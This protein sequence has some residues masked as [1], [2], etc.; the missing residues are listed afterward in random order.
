[1]RMHHTPYTSLTTNQ[2]RPY[3]LIIKPLLPIKYPV[4]F[5]QIT[6]ILFI[7]FLNCP[8]EEILTSFRLDWR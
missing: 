3:L 1:M 4:Y 7:I 5:Y 6:Q 8:A 2:I